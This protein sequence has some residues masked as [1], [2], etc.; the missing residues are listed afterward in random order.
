MRYT[1]QCAVRHVT[2]AIMGGALFT[3]IHGMQG[4][5]LTPQL[6]ATNIGFLYAFG[7][8]HCPMEEF[9]GRQSL[10]HSFASG[11]VL[12]YLGVANRLVGLPF[13]LEYTF[14]MNR[15]PLAAGGALVYGAI[16]ATIAAFQGK[17]L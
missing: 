9:S 12:G 4:A 14:Y 10:M 5:P 16:G 15:V 2:P 8:L 11:A 3:A 1:Q 17:P 6:A 13:N 7:V